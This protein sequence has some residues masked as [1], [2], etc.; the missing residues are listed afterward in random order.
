[1]TKQQNDEMRNGKLMN[2][3]VD[4]TSKQLNGELT[5]QQVSNLAE[6]AIWWNGKLIERPC[7]LFLKS[8]KYRFLKFGGVGS[9][10]LGI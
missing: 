1:L 3:Q 4:E 2:Q 9:H 5:K 10:F 6:T 7:A 8:F